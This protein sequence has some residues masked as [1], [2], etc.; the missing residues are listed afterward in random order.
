MSKKKLITYILFI[1]LLGIIAA[2]AGYKVSTRIHNDQ[3]VENVRE[4]A[5]QIEDDAGNTSSSVTSNTAITDNQTSS[6]GT[7]ASYQSPIDFDNLK[8]SNEDIYAWISIPDTTIDYPIAQHPTDDSYYLNHGADGI[9]SEYGCPY[10]ELSDNRNFIEFNTVI[11]G[12]NMND[13][14]MFGGLH[15]FENEDFFKEH[16]TLYIYTEEHT[17]TYMFFAAV[18][19]S[20]VHIPYYFDDDVEDDRKAFLQSLRTDIVE[21][22]SI[23]YEDMDVTSDSKIVTLSTCDR[24]LR[25]NRFLVVAVMIEV[26]GR[27]IQ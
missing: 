7:L 27:P 20:D 11:Y 16:R 6:S 18:M 12:H 13:G 3:V 26:D 17:F 2:T 10:T 19:Y 23:Y 25:D 5:H 4:S 9:Y 8:A 22:R 24:K 21:N 1:L 14:S 15:D